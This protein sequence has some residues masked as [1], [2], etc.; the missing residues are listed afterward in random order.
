MSQKDRERQKR[1]Q[2]RGERHKQ[3]RAG[4]P[5][6]VAS[7]PDA[8]EIRREA[9]GALIEDCRALFA[10]EGRIGEDLRGEIREAGDFLGGVWARLVF[11]LEGFL[12]QGQP[13][14]LR[15]DELRPLRQH[16]QDLHAEPV[17]DRIWTLCR[18]N[19]PE[20]YG[21]SAPEPGPDPSAGLDQAGRLALAFWR[22]H[23]GLE[24][25]K[26]DRAAALKAIREQVGRLT[27]NPKTARA[28]CDLLNTALCSL[29]PA[30]RGRKPAVPRETQLARD[31]ETFLRTHVR[32]HTEA[33]FWASSR[34]LLREVLR[35][36]VRLRGSAWLWEHPELLEALY[37]APIAALCHPPAEVERRLQAIRPD[38]QCE[39]WL[40]FL[41]Q[42]IDHE[43][44]GFEH[45]LRYEIAR[46]RLLE[47]RAKHVPMDFSVGERRDLTDA[48]E[49]LFGLLGRGVPPEGRHLPPVLDPIV[50]DYYA[51]ACRTL[52]IFKA[53]LRLSQALL[54]RHPEDHRLQCLYV[55]GA[56]LHRERIAIDGPR[57][58]SARVSSHVEPEL[59]AECADYW[60]SVSG[61]D[62]AR[63]ILYTPLAREQQKQCLLALT[64]RRLRAVSTPEACRAA[65]EGL[66]AYLEAVY[67]ALS[68]GAAVERE[69][70]FVGALTAA[71]QGTP[72]PVLS[73]AA[74][75]QLAGYAATLCRELPPAEGLVIEFLE[76]HPERWFTRAD[77]WQ[78]LEA[79]SEALPERG[80]RKLR[81]ALKRLLGRLPS[82]TLGGAAHQRLLR[83][84]GIPVERRRSPGG[85]T[86]TPV[87]ADGPRR[88]IPP[89]KPIK[90]RKTIQPRRTIQQGELFDDLGP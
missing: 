37:G 76:R 62:R 12:Y 27:G 22:L 45:R 44:L 39:E 28:L 63:A 83:R 72:L 68:H 87:N 1:R 61:E 6:R 74:F 19:D 90:P 59:F 49:G 57:D 11:E 24:A 3:K 21:P 40:G 16:F 10:R 5:H 41:A 77:G 64:R 65:L 56:L 70:V 73:Y 20:L 82:P 30:G 2:K 51:E 47:A 88:S 67:E 71:W 13:W 25:P 89:K 48:F 7:Q 32:A 80:F 9:M 58:P 86:A 33:G 52:K 38:R 4:V 54:G 78:R 81:P 69:L 23:A 60:R 36:H 50:L 46:T 8:A 42:R 17:F 84:L 53:N 55:T 15:C 66:A 34:M 75:I 18:S 31:A 14:D 79:L 29:L 26:E 85:W 35:R 43:A